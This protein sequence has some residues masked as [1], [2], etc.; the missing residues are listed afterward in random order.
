MPLNSNSIPISRPDLLEQDIAAAVSVLRSGML[1]QGNEVKNLEANVS[2]YLKTENC[3]AVS[4][5]TASLHLALISL[6]VGPGDEVILPALSY[7]ATANVIELV[8]AKCVFVDTNPRFFN[9]EESKIEEHISSRTKA[10]IPVHEFGL[11]AN[12]PVIMKLANKFNLK[13]IEDAACALG[14]TVYSKFAGTFGHFGSFSLHP[15]KAI[16]S[17]EGG[18]LITAD[19]DLDYK[20]KTLRNHGIEPDSVPMNFIAAGFNYRMTDFQAALVNSQF[21]RLENIIE[22]KSR[23]ASIYLGEIRNTV[24]RL[25]EIPGFTKH[26]WQTFHILL[27]DEN[28][29]NKLK[30][31]LRVNGIMSNYGAQCI[32]AMM[33]YRNKYGHNAESEFPNAFEAYSC[34]LAIPLYSQL[35]EDQVRFISKTI[36]NFS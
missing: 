5:G 19:S 1:V 7:I 35:K 20:I 2:G 11:C 18:L 34:G 21:S 13:V 32:P 14:A 9:I 30:E 12:M 4:N 23:L 26:T 28:Q 8:G 6:G 22:Y 15:R 33:Y 25:P 31:H 3:S 29:R 17:G 24:I 27:K 16:T 36:N 10:I